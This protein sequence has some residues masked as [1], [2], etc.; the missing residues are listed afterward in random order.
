MRIAPVVRIAARKHQMTTIPGAPC[1]NHERDPRRRYPATI[2]IPRGTVRGRA[3][4]ELGAIATPRRSRSRWMC[5]KVDARGGDHAR[6]A[7]IVGVPADLS[8]VAMRNPL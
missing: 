6:S 8:D 3:A 2:V 4:R 7:V 5:A 1:R